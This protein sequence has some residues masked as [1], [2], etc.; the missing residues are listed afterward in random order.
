MVAV[1]YK[2]NEVEETP[3][4]EVV[5]LRPLR[6]DALPEHTHYVDNGCDLHPSCLT[7]PLVRCRF[8]EPGGARKLISDDRDAGILRLHR[9]EQLDV[10]SI[11]REYRISRRTVFRVLA[12]A[13][14][15]PEAI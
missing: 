1:P 11:A 2:P 7:C 12:R 9:E 14:A 10:S 8:D 5:L 6:R 13:R 15:T 3:Q 4:A